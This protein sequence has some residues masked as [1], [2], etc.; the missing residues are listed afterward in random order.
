MNRSLHAALVKICMAI[1]NAACLPYCCHHCWNTP[2]IASLCSYPLFGLHKCS[3]NIEEC[4][5][6]Q[7]FPCRGIQFH[8]FASYTISCHLHCITTL[9]CCHLWHSNKCNGILTGRFHLYCH[10]TDNYLWCHGPTWSNKMHCFWC[11]PFS[12][13][14]VRFEQISNQASF[15]LSSHKNNMKYRLNSSVLSY[16]KL[17]HWFVRDSLQDRWFTL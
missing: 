8:N 1:G 11:S 2:S 6:V 9:L 3:P 13:T 15:L 14:S 17:L 12:Y 7:F 4:Q 10:T 5:W 16:A